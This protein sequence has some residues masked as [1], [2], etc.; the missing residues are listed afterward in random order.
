MIDRVYQ[1]VRML[2][3]TEIRGNMKP[4]DFDKALYAVMI[5]IYE[6][7]PFELN[8]WTNRQSKGLVSPGQQNI[9]DLIA[10]KIDHYFKSAP[11]VA[12]AGKFPLPTDLRYLDSVIYTTKNSEVVPCKNASEFNL[13]KRFKH[14]QPSVDFPIGFIEDKKIEILPATITNNIVINYR[15][16]PKIPKWTYIVINGAEQFNPDAGDFSDIDMHF[17]EFDVLVTG[18][19]EKFGINLKEPDLKAAAE[20]EEIQKF[21]IE[22][23]N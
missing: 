20:G 22:N 9:V 18:V 21:N 4:A 10:E 6:Q 2:A 16:N 15:R 13:L 23:S 7:Y 19:C 8:K 3:N 17:S 14:T 11:S 12:V 1:T 5:E